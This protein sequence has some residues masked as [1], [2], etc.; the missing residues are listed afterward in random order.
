MKELTPEQVTKFKG[1]GW[2]DNRIASTAQQLGYSMPKGYGTRVADQVLEGAEDVGAGLNVARQGIASGSPMQAV[3]GVVGGVGKAIG[4]VAQAVASPLNEGITEVAR[5]VVPEA[6]RTGASDLIGSGA[7]AVMN[8][9]FGKAVEAEYVK[10]K[11][12][13]PGAIA[14]AEGVAETA[15]N[16]PVIGAGL[17]AIKKAVSTT[18][19][20]ATTAGGAIKQSGV[21]SLQNN[22]NQKVLSL[23]GEV[24]GSE[25]GALAAG[26]N[27][28]RQAGGAETPVVKQSFLQKLTG[29]SEAVAA[30]VPKNNAG[31]LKSLGGV[32]RGDEGFDDAL[33]KVNAAIKRIDASRVGYT[34]LA[35]ETL[36]GMARNANVKRFSSSNGEFAQNLLKGTEGIALGAAD[37][38]ASDIVNDLISRIKANID[39]NA[40]KNVLQS[41]EKG[42]TDFIKDVKTTYGESA[43]E[44]TISGARSPTKQIVDTV[45]ANAREEIKK[46]LGKDF[47]EKYGNAA[48]ME[49]YAIDGEHNLQYRVGKGYGQSAIKAGL[50]KLNPVMQGQGVL[51]AT[52]FGTGAY[53]L[54]PNIV[55]VI[56][57]MG[58]GGALAYYGATRPILRKV[59]GSVVEEIG[60]K[61]PDATGPARQEFLEQLGI[62]AS[63]Q[64][65]LAGGDD[66]PDIE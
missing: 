8:S 63:I 50:N 5:A 14:G 20:V 6:V 34:K 35:D 38:K 9:S 33:K 47:G 37:K 39:Q 11:Q 29:T 32:L 42:V 4:G 10:M 61:L 58:I 25:A 19:K 54:F 52:A 1:M 46:A 3:Q 28:A 36:G 48:S 65:A 16:I 44:P 45:R 59:M 40:G 66:E 49:K 57:A 2:D 15:M 23:V 56:G 31:I 7:Q 53:L 18:K 60:K 43:F 27:V 26:K 24:T 30:D 51:G 22:S 41:V 55:A 12:Q 21:N 17:G 64:A 62:A 13:A